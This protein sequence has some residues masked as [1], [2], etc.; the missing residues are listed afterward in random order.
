MRLK[1]RTNLVRVSL[2]GLARGGA[3]GLLIFIFSAVS[4]KPAAAQDSQ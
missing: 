1:L 2:R 3:I 4:V